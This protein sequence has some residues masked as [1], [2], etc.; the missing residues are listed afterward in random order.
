MGTVAAWGLWIWVQSQKE[1]ETL[2]IWEWGPGVYLC[3]WAN[4]SGS[5]TEDDDP[6]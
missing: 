5:T 1:Y 3:F 6:P 2:S 4:G